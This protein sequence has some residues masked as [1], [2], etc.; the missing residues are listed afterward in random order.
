MQRFFACPGI[1]GPPRLCKATLGD[2]ARL[3]G[4]TIAERVH[5]SLPLCSL[6]LQCTKTHTQAHLV[7]EVPPTHTQPIGTPQPCPSPSEPSPGYGGAIQ[8]PRCAGGA[9]ESDDD[10]AP[11]PPPPGDSYRRSAE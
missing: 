11:G 5:S 6:H 7:S 1:Q 8:R 10:P 2:T 4:L 9:H 3:A